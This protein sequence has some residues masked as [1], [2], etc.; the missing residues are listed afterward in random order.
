VSEREV[1]HYLNTLSRWPWALSSSL[2]LLL[3][4]R[5]YGNVIGDKGAAAIGEALKHNRTLEGLE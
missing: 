2:P 5:L 1:Y 4:H 3:P